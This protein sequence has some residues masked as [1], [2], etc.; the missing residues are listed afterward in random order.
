[1]NRRV[2]AFVVIFPLLYVHVLPFMTRL[3]LVLLGVS[4]LV[5][6]SASAQTAPRTSTPTESVRQDLRTRIEAQHHGLDALEVQGDEVQAPKTIRHFYEQRAFAPVWIDDR[7]PRAAVDSL[8][9]V[10]TRAVRDG[11]RPAAY[12][13]DA[14]QSLREQAKKS[15]R[16]APGRLADLELLSTDA[17]LLYAS[18]LLTGRVSPTDITPSWNIP[19]READLVQKLASVAGG[20]SVSRVVESL[21]QPQPEYARLVRALDRYR[22]ITALGGWPTVPEGPTLRKGEEGERITLLRE[23]LQVTGDLP[24]DQT[25]PVDTFDTALHEAVVRFQERHGLNPDGA[26]GPATRAALN[27]S[28]EDRVRQLVVNLERWRWL[29]QDLGHRHVLVNIAGFRLQVV[30]NGEDVMQMRVITGRPYRQTPVFSGEISYLVFNPYWHV[31]HSIATEDK[32]PEIKNDPGYLA[33]QGFEVF[34][35]WGADARPI[36]PSTIDWSRLSQKNFP[37][38]LRQ[39]PGPLN[40]LGRVKFM[41]PNPHSVYLHDTPTRGLFARADRSFSSGCIRVERPMELAEYLLDDQ[42]EWSAQKIQD[43]LDTSSAER[44]V[45]L[46]EK[47]PVHLQYWTAWADEGGAVHFRRDVYERDEA[48]HQALTAPAS[49][50]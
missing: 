10:L 22:H 29:P 21:R 31:P 43:A 6:A 11:L 3:L 25:E 14:L 45:I 26:V 47:V 17:F 50:K 36:D 24:T 18:H 7:G 38:R 40:A 27:V 41:F 20:G 13:L 9:A 2:S 23:R 30:E 8:L 28:A 39:K 5:P 1:M 33:R 12:H 4:V 32:L 37:Y 35:G 42:T 34:Q 19:Q 16:A 49:A 48:L 44:A 46:R 15:R